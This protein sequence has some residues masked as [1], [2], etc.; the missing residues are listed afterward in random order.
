MSA[1]ARRIAV[2]FIAAGSPID[3][4]LNI[5]RQASTAGQQFYTGDM[6]EFANPLP[7][8]QQI[9]LERQEYKNQQKGQL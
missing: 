7:E 8:K 2:E 3:I 6:S 4:Q 1:Q 9:A 5:E